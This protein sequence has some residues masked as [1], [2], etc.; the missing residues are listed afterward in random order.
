MPRSTKHPRTTPLC[1]AR[2]GESTSRTHE[3]VF[4]LGTAAADR[5]R[6]ATTLA[7]NAAVRSILPRD[8]GVEHCD[9]RTG[10]V[11]PAGPEA[12]EE[13]FERRLNHPWTRTRRP[14]R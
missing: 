2:G 10:G 9:A 13:K 12:A 5:R 11:G 7:A 1:R 8:T 4:T 6:D 14:R 3:A